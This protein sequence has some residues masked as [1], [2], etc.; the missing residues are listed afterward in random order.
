MEDSGQLWVDFTGVRV[1]ALI[2]LY[3]RWLDSK[4][5]RSFLNDQ[6]AGMAIQRLAFDFSQLP[7]LKYA[8]FTIAAR[9]RQIDDWVA[10]YLSAQPNATVIDLGC[11]F[12]SRVFRLDPAPAHLWVDVDFPDIIEVRNQLL[13]RHHNHVTV[14]ASITESDWLEQIPS[15]RPAI[16]IADSLLMFL[17]EHDVLKLFTRLADHFPAGEFVFTTYSALLKRY[18]AKRGSPPFFVKY[19]VTPTRWVS[20]NSGDIGN[21]DKRFRLVERRSQVDRRLHAHAPFYDRAMCALITA[22]RPAR[23]A[24]AIQR[25]RF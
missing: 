17:S 9:T 1:T 18:E 14:G 3:A 8:R 20:S 4:D 23:Y 11:G 25:Y 5:Q 19:N 24:G 15:D 21:L 7:Q 22:Y 13:P 12:D 2:T 10:Q 6:W 16:I